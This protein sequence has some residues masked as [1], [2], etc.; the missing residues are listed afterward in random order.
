MFAVDLTPVPLY[1]QFLWDAGTTKFQAEHVK[2]N[3]FTQRAPQKRA[4]RDKMLNRKKERKWE[5]REEET[6]SVCLSLSLLFCLLSVREVFFSTYSIE[7][8]CSRNMIPACCW[9]CK[10][11]EFLAKAPSAVR[12]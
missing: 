12:V 10:N 2:M 5:K 8:G 1:F 3:F 4:K 9:E 11:F 6:E 7:R